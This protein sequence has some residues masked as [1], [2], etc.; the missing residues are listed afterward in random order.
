MVFCKSL[1]I[2]ELEVELN[3][4]QNEDSQLARILLKNSISISLLGHDQ[5]QVYP[6]QSQVLYDMNLVLL[7]SV[8]N[9]HFQLPNCSKLL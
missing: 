1:F 3:Y 5:V 7:Y 9:T 2:A 4:D 6:K 8:L